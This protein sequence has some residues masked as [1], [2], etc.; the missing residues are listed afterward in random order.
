MPTIEFARLLRK[1]QTHAESLLWAAL[2]DRGIGFKFRRQVTI[3][4]YIVDF[5]CHETKI[6]IELDGDSHNEKREQD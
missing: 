2:R 3:E 6:I 1:G 4:N 5:C